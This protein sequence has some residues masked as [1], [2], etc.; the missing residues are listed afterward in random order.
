MNVKLFQSR[1][2]LAG[3]DTIVSTVVMAA[4]YSIIL[5][6]R[7]DFKNLEYAVSVGLRAFKFGAPCSTEI[8]TESQLQS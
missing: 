1:A 4:H 3:F 8:L 5:I 7:Q 6:F 2:D